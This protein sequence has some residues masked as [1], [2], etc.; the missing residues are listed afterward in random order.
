MERD[1]SVLEWIKPT[2]VGQY[3]VLLLIL[4]VDYV[5]KAIMEC[6]IWISEYPWSITQPHTHIVTCHLLINYYS[7]INK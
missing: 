1:M 6:A 4:N 2:S 3:L 7:L 5:M